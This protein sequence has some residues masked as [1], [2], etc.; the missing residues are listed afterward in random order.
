MDG[1]RWSLTCVLSSESVC[2]S[3]VIMP[4][5]REPTTMETVVGYP[6]IYPFA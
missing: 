2:W 5:A 1:R 6:C 3:P 4:N